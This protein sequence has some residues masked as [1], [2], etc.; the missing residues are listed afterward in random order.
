VL[1]QRMPGTGARLG[2]ARALLVLLLL[3]FFSANSTAALDPEHHLRQYAHTAWRVQD[4]FEVVGTVAQTTD[5][6][7]WFGTSNRLLRFDGVKFVPYDL[8]PITPALRGINYLLGARDGSLWIGT[9]IGLARLKDGKLQWYSDPA[10]H[11]GITAILEDPDGTIWLTRYHVPKGEGPLCR[12]EGN[13]L[14]CYGEADGIAVRYG[15]GLARDAE[16]NLWFGSSALCRWRPGSASTYLN[17]VAKRPD[18]GDG[19]ID[20]AAGP[21][22]TIWATTEV[23][24]PGMGVLSS[25]GGKWA[26]YV[27]PGFDGSKVGSHALFMDREHTLWIGT[28]KDGLY[29]VHDG[30]AEHFGTADGLS[31][32]DIGLIFE[33]HEGNIWVLTDG[34]IDMFRDM[35][36]VSYSELEGLSDNSILAVLG[37]QDGSVWISNGGVID[38]LKDG[39][40]SVLPSRGAFNEVVT[41]LFQDH[42]GVVWIGR[43]DRLFAYE[44]GEFRE[45]KGPKGAKID[46]GLVA[47]ITEDTSGNIWFLTEKHHL[48][49]ID[50]GTARQILT[51]SSD[52]RDSGSLVP[53]HEGGI[54]VSSRND[55]LTHYRDGNV[56]TISLN[57]PDSSFAISELL[58]DGDGALLVATTEGLFRW[59]NQRWQVLDSRDG[60]PSNVVLSVLRDDTNAVWVRCQGGLVRISDSEFDEWRRQSGRKPVMEIFDKWDGA[61]SGRGGL[62]VQP[63]ATKS[64]DGRLWFG[65]GF[66]VQSINPGR[67]LRNPIPPPVHMEKVIADHREFGAA[68]PI[69]LPALTRDIEV[70]YT[71]LSFPVPQKV[72]F[73]Y[74]L[75]GR[76]AGWVEAG[77][78]RQAFYSSLRPGR[79]RFHVIASNNDG[80]WNEEGARL[81]L[82]VA[83]AWYQKSWVQGFFLVAGLLCV[84]GLYQLRIR[85]VAQQFNL[86]LEARVGERTSIARELHDTLLQSLNGLLLR[87]QAA[88]NLLPER[89]EDA[90]HKLDSAIDQASQAIGEGRRAVQGL[91]DSTVVTNDLVVALR[92]LEEDLITG[93]AGEKAPAF[94]V[95]VEGSPQLLHPIVRDEVYRI[96]A[97]ALR[98]AFRHAQADRIELEIRYNAHEFRVRIRDDGR[99]IDPHFLVEGTGHWGLAGMR[100]RAKVLGASLEVWSNRD[101]GTEIQLTIPSSVAYVRSGT[102]RWFWSSRKGMET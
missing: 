15:L 73:R 66:V 51:V 89:P 37:L 26:T 97:E 68:A 38:V 14:H 24:L 42:K 30:V 58:V 4:G 27:V 31:G 23:A 65:A 53:D 99:G 83:P 41:A 12:V 79:Y 34:G 84:W 61:R 17:E 21:S 71:A 40:H 2:I 54:W 56:R 50:N 48:F 78:R 57:R 18:A 72:S 100:E 59:D 75:E 9:Q 46:G 82:S 29:R 96:A 39:H 70:D 88:S 43:S 25:S 98:N 91:R 33:D 67:P 76:D 64:R 52:N 32:R 92:T 47:A 35:A 101:S 3:Y 93:G 6:Y 94:D 36:V 63:P 44:N 90:K 87:F 77:T 60:L 11:S 5:G 1:R 45:L 86:R 22:G 10:Q 85:Q 13:G 28:T 74:Q 19:I 16:G 102:H 69:E 7:L 55:V 81:D 62:L 95:T 8:S 80:V 20:I 49:R